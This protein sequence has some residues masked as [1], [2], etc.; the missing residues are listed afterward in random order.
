V[1]SPEKA[2]FI[3]DRQLKSLRKTLNKVGTRRL[4]QSVWSDYV[5]GAHHSP[6]YFASKRDFVER[7]FT[8]GRPQAV[9]DIGCNKGDFSA[10]AARNGARVVALD[11]EDELVAA[12]WLRAKAEGLDILPL[13]VDWTR[14][15]PAIG[16]RNRESLSF[17]DRARGTFDCVMMLAVIHHMLVTERIPLDE[18]FALAAEV[19][20]DRLLIE[21]VPP[22]DPKFKMVTRGNDRLYD[23][24]TKEYFETIANKYFRLEQS[25]KMADSDRWLYLMRRQPVA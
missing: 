11:G 19:T 20:T 4:R 17:L 9:L 16:W 2:S 10:I 23:F 18:I 1:S 3:L 6:A 25:Q 24:L 7:A 5:D 12:V 22:G 14:P 15:T 21:F 8:D 13:V